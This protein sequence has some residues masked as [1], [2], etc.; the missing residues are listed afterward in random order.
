MRRWGRSVRLFE[1][2][3]G[4]DIHLLLIMDPFG[5]S[6]VY[7]VVVAQSIPTFGH[8]MDCS[9]PGSSVHGLFQARI[10]EWVAIF[11]SRL[12]CIP[13]FIMCWSIQSK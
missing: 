9:Q 5:E 1:L 11:S 13:S 8:S 3:Q 10:V 6:K 2:V 12:M 4:L 7:V